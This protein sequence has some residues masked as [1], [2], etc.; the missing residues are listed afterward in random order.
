MLAKS[1]LR[2]KQASQRAIST[3]VNA[4]SE[5][6]QGS[7]SSSYFML[8]GALALGALAFNSMQK[9]ETEAWIY[10]DDIGS[11]N[12][13]KGYEEQ[14]NSVGT[15][16][17]HNYWPSEVNFQTWNSAT[18]RRGFKVFT[19]VCQGCH[20]AMHKKYDLLVDKGFTQRELIDKMI[21]L[22]KLHPAHQKYKGD[23]FN[24]WDF[25]QRVIH[26]RIWSPYFT[27][28]QAKNAN[29]G[30]WPKDLTKAQ[31]HNPGMINFVYNVM[32][33]YHYNSPFGLDV[34]EGKFFNPYFDHMI[35]GM[36]PQ[37]YDGM[38]EYEDGTKASGPQMAHDVSE[39]LMFLARSK[40]PDTK[41]VIIQVLA[42]SVLFYP[43]S[44]FYTK[45]HMVNLLSHRFEVYAVKSGGYKKFREKMFKTNKL[46]G[47]HHGQYS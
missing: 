23:Y 9:K 22:Q 32:P 30:L 17:G 42:L 27:V 14:V 40:A 44:Y 43:I 38:I 31:T 36:P 12:G 28:H 10:R 35:L 6:S 39:Y 21:F 25:R 8:G 37:L 7:S 29:G 33:G 45:Y 18:L 3:Q 13:I 4:K 19:R 20:G 34:P 24:E 16:H 11:P 46:Y 2:S 1:L 15:R 41:M 47:N 26:D 5:Q